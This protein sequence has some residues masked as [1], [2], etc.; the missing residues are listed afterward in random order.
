MIEIS[1]EIETRQE[2]LDWF[3][4]E[5]FPEPATPERPARPSPV[6][7]PRPGYDRSL[8][9]DEVLVKAG[10]A[11]NGA[12]FTRLFNGDCSGYLSQSEADQALCNM[13]AFWCR[14]DAEQMDRL[15]LLSGMANREKAGRADYRARTIGKAIAGCREVYSGGGKVRGYGATRGAFAGLRDHR[16]D[17]SNRMGEWAGKSYAEAQPAAIDP[18][19]ILE[20]FEVKREYVERLGQEE[21]LIENLLI[22]Q[23]I[24]VCIAMSGGGKT[25]FWYRYAAPVLARKGYTVWYLDCDSPASEHREMKEIADRHGFRFLNADANVGAGINELKKN[26]ETIA[27]SDCDLTGHVFIFDTLK[28]FT[29]LM[30]KGSVKDFF[31]LCR[32]LTSKGATVVL[33]GHANKYRSKPEGHL[34]AEGVGDVRSDTDELIFFERKRNENTGGLDVTTDPDPDHGAKVRGLFEPF[35]FHIGSDREVT[36]YE[37]VVEMPDNTLT[38]TP[39][40]TEEEIL[41][42][43]AGFLAEAGEPVSQSALVNQVRAMTG[44]AHNRVRGLIVANSM[45]AGSEGHKRLVYTIEKR[46]RLDYSLPQG[47]PEQGKLFED[48]PGFQRESSF[49]D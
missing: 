41:D 49:M 16:Q 31:T 21:H 32:K 19:A 4:A 10:E 5:H 15:F 40:A 43:A 47:T 46:G 28:K 24:L 9:D 36:V 30:S 2:A 38:A 26:L 37:K 27:T 22:K 23:H 29:D 45:K 17:Q 3:L 33:L 18:A 12:K 1:R 35:S 39:T 34:I 8:S 13:L 14:C 42:A 6:V 20:R 7:P 48:E 11:A 44:A 25:A